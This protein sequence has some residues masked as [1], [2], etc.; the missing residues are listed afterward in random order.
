M[1]DDVTGAHKI[2]RLPRARLRRKRA[3]RPSGLWFICGMLLLM[4]SAS[5]G[6]Q[7]QSINARISVVS[8]TPPRVRVEA[9]RAQ[10]AKA[11]SFRNAYAGI[12]GLGER[13]ENVS[14]SDAQGVEVAARKLA[15]GEYE[16]AREATKIRYELKLDPPRDTNDTAHVSWLTTTRGVLMPGDLLP[17]PAARAKLNLTL[18]DNWKVATVETINGGGQYELEDAESS[19]FFVGA[20]LRTTQTSVSGMELTFATA[21]E[22]AFADEDVLGVVRDI[23]KEHA[24][25]N[26]SIPRKKALFML[27]PFPQTSDAT[28]WSAET[29]G[30]TVFFLSGRSTSKAAGLARLSVP[31]AH[32]LLHL[33]IPNALALSGDYAWFY[34]GF[35]VYQ[36]TRVSVE[37]G[38][39][40]FQDSL[41]SLARAYDNYLAQ[42][43]QDKYSLVEASAR[44]W[45]GSGGLIYHKGMLVAALYDLTV[46]QSSRGKRSLDDVYRAL[47]R[48]HRTGV[49]RREGNAAV[50]AAL[51]S[52]DGGSDFSKRYL[53]SASPLDLTAALDTFGLKMRRN[54]ARTQINVADS[55]SRA[56]RDLLRQMGYN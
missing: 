50:I 17:L 9:E 16:A 43:E 36:S 15:P 31:L 5:P 34:E 55:L 38:Y 13:I 44:R 48:Q 28:R 27:A 24:R 40:T 47:F 37:L 41:D 53:E 46:R 22:W 8:L 4:L 21:G 52:V 26:G 30:G 56:Q 45:G 14:L 20:D 54:G 1:L 51:N 6:A 32:E 12:I 2:M 10:G 18:P 23:I 7:G 49:E 39:L 3:G 19:V 33:W 25:I 42:R 29:R 11:W 35:T